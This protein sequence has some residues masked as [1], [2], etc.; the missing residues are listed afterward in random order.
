M[1]FGL[2]YSLV[3]GFQTRTVYLRQTWVWCLKL[4]VVL[5]LNFNLCL[6]FRSDEIT[7]QIRIFI[8]FF[9]PH[10]GLENDTKGHQ[11]FVALRGQDGSPQPRGEMQTGAT[12]LSKALM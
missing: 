12:F 9:G 3:A 6:I 2:K 11:S 7:H 1:V 5:N 10:W 8:S 4:H